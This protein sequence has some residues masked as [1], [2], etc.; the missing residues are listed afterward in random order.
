M[1]FKLTNLP[2]LAGAAR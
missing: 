1:L 2:L